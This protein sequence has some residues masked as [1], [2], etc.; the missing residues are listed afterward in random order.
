MFLSG[1]SFENLS[2]LLCRE[3]HINM[4]TIPVTNFDELQKILKRE[5]V[6]ERFGIKRIGVFG[7]FA[8]GEQFN[9]IDLLIEDD[10]DYF[11]RTDLKKVLQKL[12]QTKID[13]L[14]KKYAEP[15]ILFRA[16]KDVKYVTKD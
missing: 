7:S 15:I 11:K 10:L 8:R 12:L 13:L 6:F 3:Q 9:D 2:C 4:Q 14:V 16:L 1:F 5:K